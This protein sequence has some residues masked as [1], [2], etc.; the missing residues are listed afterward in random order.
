MSPFEKQDPEKS[1]L[2]RE[3][4]VKSLQKHAIGI[5]VTCSAWT[6]ATSSFFRIIKK[7]VTLEL[8]AEA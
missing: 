2:H 8:W 5:L 6:Y 7:N 1:D 3:P 4:I